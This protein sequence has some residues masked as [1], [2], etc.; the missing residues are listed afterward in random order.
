MWACTYTSIYILRVFSISFLLF[1]QS[2]GSRN[3]K[4]FWLQ[5]SELK[6]IAVL[7]PESTG[8]TALCVQLA[9]HFNT[10]Y[11]PEFARQY[12]LSKQNQYNYDDVVYCLQQQIALEDEMQKQATGYL[13]CDTELINFKVWFAD[14]FNKVP[15]KLEE[16]IKSPRYD[17]TL[18]TYYDV[19]F[20]NDILR[21][22]ENRREYFFDW[23]KREL[24][25]NQKT[26]AVI[27]GLGPERQ[28]NAVAAMLNYKI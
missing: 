15:D 7:G 12:L 20:E 18:L 10:A 9:A 14:V 25:S 23:Y 6:K 8:K 19:P 28:K 16:K 4:K 21:T 22:N 17:L 1:L 11:V 27:K 3:G 2:S 5:V 24:E 26:Y 13:F